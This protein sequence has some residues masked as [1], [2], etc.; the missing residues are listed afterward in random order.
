MLIGHQ[1]ARLHLLTFLQRRQ[2]RIMPVVLA[3]LGGVGLSFLV[4]HREACKAHH[5]PGGAKRVRRRFHVD[6]RLVD[7]R[8]AHL[9]G[10][11]PVP[12]QGVQSQ[13]L[14][15]QV[16]GLRLAGERSTEVGRIASCASCAP[17]CWR[18]L[19]GFAAT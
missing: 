4:Q 7:D 10:H 1:F 18:C 17:F 3:L 19:R 14:G 2:R 9:A 15:G 11:Q 5:R 6:A 8:R 13:L 16:R 12:Y